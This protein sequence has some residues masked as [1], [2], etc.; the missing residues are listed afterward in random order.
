M[1]SYFLLAQPKE[2]S[3]LNINA[4]WKNLKLKVQYIVYTEGARVWT[5]KR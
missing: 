1:T 3:V 4:K 2:Q 5:R